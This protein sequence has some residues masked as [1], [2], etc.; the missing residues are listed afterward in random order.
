V[1]V[2]PLQQLALVVVKIPMTGEQP[3]AHGAL[4][5]ER[6]DRDETPGILDQYRLD[7]FGAV[8]QECVYGSGDEANHIAVFAH[9][10]EQR[11]KR[12]AG[13][14]AERPQKLQAARSRGQKLRT[15]FP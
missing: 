6:A 3:L 7:V 1:C 5:S 14:G 13:I 11:L 9:Q 8:N 10:I 12:I 2:G 4:D 15:D